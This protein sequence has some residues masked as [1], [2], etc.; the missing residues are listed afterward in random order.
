M[1]LYMTRY[2]YISGYTGDENFIEGYP[3]KY[4]RL[5]FLKDEIKKRYSDASSTEVSETKTE[6]PYGF[7]ENKMNYPKEKI[8]TLFF[9]KTTIYDRLAY[10]SIPIAIGGTA[11]YRMQKG[12]DQIK[13]KENAIKSILPFTSVKSYLRHLSVPI[14]HQ[15]KC[16]ISF[17]RLDYP[18]NIN[19]SG[20]KGLYIVK[21]K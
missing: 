3:A 16:N 10:I 20:S 8:K 11:Y 18:S 17:L 15:D 2:C 19:E 6:F 4:D 14:A 21:K 5:I 13:F 12:N 9:Q 1:L 7:V